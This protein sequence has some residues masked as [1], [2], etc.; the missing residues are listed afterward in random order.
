MKNRLL[1]LGKMLPLRA[2]DGIAR[3][4]PLVRFG[5][6]SGHLREWKFC[7]F[8]SKRHQTKHLV[9]HL[10][11]FAS[12][13]SPVQSRSRPPTSESILRNFPQLGSISVQV[14]A[15]S[16]PQRPGTASLE[17]RA[18]RS[19][20]LP[21]AKNGRGAPAPCL[22]QISLQIIARLNSDRPRSY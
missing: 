8:P 22:D 10:L 11:C 17:S 19:V 14:K 13:R 2:V 1:S 21:L 3:G 7:Q 4:A 16:L 20:A 12:R 18:D 6:T 5:T 15:S 9:F